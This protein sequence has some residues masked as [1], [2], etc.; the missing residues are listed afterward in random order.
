ML[1]R[2]FAQHARAENWF[3]ARG[4]LSAET[5]AAARRRTPV[6]VTPEAALDILR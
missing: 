6:E 3:A 1:L 4:I 5:E 2:R